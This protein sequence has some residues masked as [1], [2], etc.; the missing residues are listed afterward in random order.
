MA[1]AMQTAFQHPLMPL[2]YTRA[3]RTVAASAEL[4]ERS[5]R[6]FGKPSFGLTSTKL[7]DDTVK[8]TETE[9]T[10]RPFCTLKHFAREGSNNHPRLLVVAPLSGHHATL[11]RGTVEALLP[12]HD[13]YIT[14]WT[15]ARNVPLSQGEFGLDT[16]ISYILDF[17]NHLGPGTHIMAVCQPAV[18]VLVAV[19]LL[20]QANSPCQP[21]SMILMGGP[22]DASAA[23]TKVTELAHK[24]DL[25]WFKKSMIT[26]IPP[27]YTG[28]LRRVYPGFLQ[29]AGFMT[30]NLDKHVGAHIKMFHTLIKGDGESAESHRKFYDE[31]LSVMDLPA[32]FYLDTIERVFQRY[33]LPRGRF[34]WRGLP[35]QPEAIERTALMTI[36]GELDDISAVGQTAAAHRLCHNIPPAMRVQSLQKGVGHYGIFNGRRWREGTMPEVREFILKHNR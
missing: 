17:L 19:S 24:H 20:A 2:A 25:A 16:Y 14:D 7:G 28:A 5:T 1:E 8:I 9:V 36:E 23:S 29:L 18:P 31:Y 6:R 26:T 33:D 15:D 22:I 32:E 11:L 21:P 3:G 4:L 12:A 27:W 10:T 30:M 35:V 13:V 34:T